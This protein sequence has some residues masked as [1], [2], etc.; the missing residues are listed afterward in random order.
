[1]DTQGG[2]NLGGHEGENRCKTSRTKIPAKWHKSFLI[3]KYFKP[4][5][6]QPGGRDVPGPALPGPLSPEEETEKLG[7]R[8][9]DTGPWRLS[10]NHTATE[11]VP[12]P[13]GSYSTTTGLE[14]EDAEAWTPLMPDRPTASPQLFTSGH[15]PQYLVSDCQ[16]KATRHLKGNRTTVG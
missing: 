10:T 8:P 6:N 5:P 3:S 9:R 15:V 1:M 2:G 11:Q 13:V 16:Q 4:G 7:S 14:P 12:S